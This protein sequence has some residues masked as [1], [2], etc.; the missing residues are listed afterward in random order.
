[1]EPDGIRGKRICIPPNLHLLFL[2]PYSPELDPVEHLWDEIREKYFHNLVF[3]SLDALENL[4]AMPCARWN[5]IRK[6]FIPLSP[7]H[8]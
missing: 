3:D 1:M 6:K 5:S 8:G 7:G 4:Y 2:P